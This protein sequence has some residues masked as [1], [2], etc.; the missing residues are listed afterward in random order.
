LYPYTNLSLYKDRHLARG[1]YGPALLADGTFWS[2]I[3]EGRS[4]YYA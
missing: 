4:W 3:P 2:K 1:A